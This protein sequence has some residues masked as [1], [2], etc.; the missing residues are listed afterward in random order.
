MQWG[1]AAANIKQNVP[2]ADLQALMGVMEAFAGEAVYDVKQI[3]AMSQSMAQM[4]FFIGDVAKEM[5]PFYAQLEKT[6]KLG[7]D[8]AQTID[9]VNGVLLE[10]FGK[11]SA[12]ALEALTKFTLQTGL[13]DEEFK[14]VA[15]SASAFNKGLK[16][17]GVSSAEAA[18]F[19][20]ELLSGSI[21]K[22]PKAFKQFFHEIKRGNF[23]NVSRQLGMLQEQAR[24]AIQAGTIDQFADSVGLSVE[25]ATQI[26][27]AQKSA[28][29]ITAEFKKMEDVDKFLDTV[30]QKELDKIKSGAID[31]E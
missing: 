18:K 19:S 17:I 1:K 21:S 25:F 3:S 15:I 31:E 27:N 26:G 14:K 6:G 22:M 29:E 24:A 8:F 23:D 13:S 2:T 20:S 7:D 5:V 28:A 30:Q 9:T 4:G 10:G 12:M 16:E 11:K